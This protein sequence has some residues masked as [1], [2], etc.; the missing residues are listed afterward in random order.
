[1]IIV[2]SPFRISIVAGNDMPEYYLGRGS[3][4]VSS[5]INKYLFT[6]LSE[7]RDDLIEVISA[8]Y[9]SIKY[10]DIS[11]IDE[12]DDIYGFVF[13][14]FKTYLWRRKWSGFNLFTSAQVPSQTGLGGS[15]IL[16][17]SLIQAILL[18]FQK[19]LGI[20][21]FMDKKEVAELAFEIEHGDMQRAVG[22]QDMYA[23]VTGG[24][25]KF[26]ADEHGF[27]TAKRLIQTPP[28]LESLRRKLVLYYTC[29]KHSAEEI[30]V[31]QRNDIKQLDESAI[32]NMQD[33]TFHA[34]GV[35]EKI[36]A[37]DYDY[38]GRL[39]HQLWE[40]K[41]ARTPKASNLEIDRLYSFGRDNG[42]YGGKLVGSGGSGFLLFYCQEDK[43]A[44]LRKAFATSGLTEMDFQFETEGI[45]NVGGN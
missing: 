44:Q 39:M 14:R 10:Y 32:K 36:M 45:C 27:V 33:I 18:H 23:T 15:S 31:K 35:A 6:V 9:Q 1:M 43:Q 11:K 22:K 40:M 37:G 2:K 20:G 7:R 12:Y 8:D 5:T 13:R 19:N 4:W 25:T 17:C 38:W 41:K 28:A 34:D 29:M 21:L 42:A 24:V 30:L 26:S 16:I 3:A